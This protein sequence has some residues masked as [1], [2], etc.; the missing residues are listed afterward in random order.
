MKGHV[1]HTQSTTTAQ[2]KGLRTASKSAVTALLV[3][4]LVMV[5][6]PTMPAVYADPILD[7]EL[8]EANNLDA[9]GNQ[10]RV[11][12]TA[13]LPL[14][15]ALVYRLAPGDEVGGEPLLNE[16]GAYLRTNEDGYLQGSISVATGDQLYALAPMLE[17]DSYTLYHT[18]GTLTNAGMQT[19]EVTA[20]GLH[21]LTVTA[22]NP[23][24]LFH[25]AV[26]LEWD[27][28]NDPTYIQQLEFDL[29]RA[30]QYLYDITNGQAALGDVVVSQN[31]DDWGYSHIV[32]HAT[33]SLR[34]FAAQGGIVKEPT[35]DPEHPEI[36]YDIGQIAM[37]ATWNRYGDPGHNLGNDWP[38][39]LAHEL[40]HY[41]FFQD[42]VYMGLNQD[43]VLIP[44][45]SCVGSVMGD[46][47][48]DMRNT[49]FIADD[50]NWNT[51]CADTL[52]N[53]TLGRDEWDTAQLWYPELQ[54][55][56]T[57]NAGPSMMPFDLTVIGTYQPL[58]PTN[59]LEDPTFYLDYTNGMI[60]SS[61][62]RAYILRDDYVVDMGSPI[63]GQNRVL[64]RGAQPGDDLCVFDRARNQYGCETIQL[65]DDRIA[66]EE[67]STWTPMI[68]INPVSATTLDIRVENL[69]AGLPLNARLYP[70][71]GYGE[72]P[73][74]L[75]EQDGA[76]VGTFELTDV[77][78]VG[79][80]RLWV[81][82]TALEDNPRREAM[83]AYTIGGNP[84]R[85]R[86]RGPE[87]RG[88][89]GRTRGR[90]PLLLDGR[91]RGR[92]PLLS[93]GRTR[94]RSPM[95]RGGDG[96]T[97]GRGLDRGRGAS[98]LSPDG[99]MFFFAA[100]PL[101]FAEG[102]FYTV[103]DM[104]GLPSLPPGRTVVGHG[105]NL[106]ATPGAPMLDGSISFEYRGEDVVAA[107][108]D[109]ET[110]TVYFWDGTT[111]TALPTI[112]DPYYNFASARSQGT[113]IY[114]L[115]SSVEISLELYG[116]NLIAYPVKQ[117]RA[118][119]DA[120]VSIDGKYRQVLGHR[121]LNGRG[122]LWAWQSYIPNLPPMFQRFNTLHELEYGRGYFVNATE[123]TTLYLEHDPGATA[124]SE[125]D[126]RE[127]M[128]GMPTS[129]PATFYGVVEASEDFTPTVDMPVI[130]RVGDTMCGEAVTQ[131]ADG[132][133]VY[134]VTV[135]ADEA[136]I[137]E[138][139]GTAGATV[140][141][142]VGD[143]MQYTTA[144]WDSS[145]PSQLSLLSGEQSV[146][147][148]VIIR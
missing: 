45:D 89:G 23:L 95:R 99:Q 85:T 112:R 46:P 71:Y 31:A 24:M 60:G 140:T 33:N 43:G 14:A 58:T 48:T 133:I 104:A 27:A 12:D 92:A 15:E 142:Q 80:I 126:V 116:W 59:A 84:G 41:L 32:V 146:Y 34:P 28:S 57:V 93:D 91:T 61:E 132:E 67:D 101:V 10:I 25:L 86:G 40:G 4:L 2:S 49:E 83:I 65:G 110:L 13:G 68:Q 79:T 76:Y 64:A 54:E 69:P 134:M 39:V 37:G 19:Y 66:L 53:R 3:L 148:P 106:M 81:D 102:E 82:E 21:E 136:G 70:E 131:D 124:W 94:G 22:D 52:A 50:A 26:S 35:A 5:S 98:M 105:Y 17:E 62:A 118:V 63:G 103:Q 72:E 56:D 121:P 44:V 141:F 123:P 29:Y 78:M 96:R 107:N 100:N 36:V 11:V 30:S 138:G 42:E 127:S 120:L 109:E 125:E 119:E 8:D 113:G 111:W 114:V 38:V 88:S 74:T 51:N 143:Q 75:S 129:I 139:C 77:A 147:L 9:D 122:Y 128:Q 18:N 7:V 135:L 20:P 115:M 16:E 108:A 73:I 90:S 145:E 97:R 55:P 137:V 47:Y 144:T 6:F 130:A 117:T 87:L 1:I